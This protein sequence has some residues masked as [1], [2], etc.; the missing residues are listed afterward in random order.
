LP[1]DVT[2]DELANRL[3]RFG[4]VQSRQTGSHMRL[5]TNRNG[6]HHVTVPRHNPLKVGTLA[7][8]LGD[9]A[10]HLGMTRDAVARELFD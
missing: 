9:V 10:A 7:R 5:T 4:Y 6:Q 1:R 2:G 8:I 3:E